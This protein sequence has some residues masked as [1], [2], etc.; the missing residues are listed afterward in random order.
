M[1]TSPSAGVELLGEQPELQARPPLGPA[2]RRLIGL[3]R[4]P[5]CFGAAKG[6]LANSPYVPIPAGGA[7]WK[8]SFAANPGKWEATIRYAHAILLA[9]RPLQIEG[10][11]SVSM[12]W[13]YS[14]GNAIRK[15]R[16]SEEPL[17]CPFPPFDHQHW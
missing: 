7:K 9:R 15:M 14:P 17:L 4:Q 3:A 10:G 12:T 1:N 13:R 5:K 16:F 6:P 8:R 2:V 11:Q